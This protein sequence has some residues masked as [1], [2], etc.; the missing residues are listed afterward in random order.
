MYFTLK[1][2]RAVSEICSGGARARTLEQSNRPQA[3]AWLVRKWCAV[4]MD[5]GPKL[6]LARHGSPTQ[7]PVEL[8][9]DR[10]CLD[11]LRSS[12]PPSL[13]HGSRSPGSSRPSSS[14]RWKP[15]TSPGRAASAGMRQERAGHLVVMDGLLKLSAPPVVAALPSSRARARPTSAIQLMGGRPF[16]PLR[17]G[18][19]AMRVGGGHVFLPPTH[20]LEPYLPGAQMPRVVTSSASAPRL[21]LRKKR[22]KSPADLEKSLARMG[23]ALVRETA[24]EQERLQAE[25]QRLHDAEAALRKAFEAE[26]SALKQE[27][28]PCRALPVNRDLHAR[29]ARPKHAS[30]SLL[31]LLLLAASSR[32]PPRPLSS[33]SPRPLLA[34]TYIMCNACT[35]P[36]P[37][38]HQACGPTQV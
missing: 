23:D 37:V 8:D 22:G 6:P 29:V 27:Y 32:R 2:R 18:S 1:M 17:P 26:L 4:S 3:P 10:R 7:S 28:A 12:S 9:T 38:G 30:Q 24:Y 34:L 35:R 33:P 5:A 21:P 16:P 19:A 20:P 15:I 11:T 14:P 36:P 31:M 13:E 25:Q